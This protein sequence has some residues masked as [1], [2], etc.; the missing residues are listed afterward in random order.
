M[1]N[2]KFNIVLKAVF[3]SL[4]FSSARRAKNISYVWFARLVYLKT[5]PI[6][7]R[8][9]KK[10]A[11]DFHLI[12]M[13]GTYGKHLF[14]CTVAWSLRSRSHDSCT[15][16]PDIPHDTLCPYTSP[17]LFVEYQVVLGKV[18]EVSPSQVNTVDS[19]DFR[20]TESRWEKGKCSVFVQVHHSYNMAVI[21]EWQI[22]AKYTSSG[23]AA[24]GM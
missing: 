6:I 23:K 19:S 13:A 5:A 2:I 9:A 12:S 10:K 24:L 1:E 17:F 4:S 22:F 16:P 20:H 3:G 11:N 14:S 15:W 21:L 8:Y 7:L 18:Q